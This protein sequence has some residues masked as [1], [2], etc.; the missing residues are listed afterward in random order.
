MHGQQV[1]DE[2]AAELGRTQD[3]DVAVLE[4]GNDVLDA[5]VGLDD[6]P[7]ALDDGAVLQNVVAIASVVVA[8]AR[9][10]FLSFGR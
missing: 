8:V 5:A 10:C 1:I 3:G 2:G 6:G 9:D 7:V 4:A